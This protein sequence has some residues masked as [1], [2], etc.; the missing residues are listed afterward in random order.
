MLALAF[1]AFR[2]RSAPRRRYTQAWLREVK[3]A[4]F[5]CW[6]SRLSRDGV[7]KNTR[8][9]ANNIQ[10]PSV[11][12]SVCSFRASLIKTPAPSTIWHGQDKGPKGRYGYAQSI[13]GLCCQQK[14][15][16]STQADC[17]RQ[18]LQE[19]SIPIG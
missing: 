6:P 17:G 3:V 2:I 1:S 9:R 13:N 4:S 8:T 16:G 14:F 7:R 5:V 11:C 15:T 18:L 12:L 19:I 10:H